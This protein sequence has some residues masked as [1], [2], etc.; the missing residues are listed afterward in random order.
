MWI[1]YQVWTSFAHVQDPLNCPAPES[2]HCDDIRDFSNI[3]PPGWSQT[4]IISVFGGRLDLVSLRTTQSGNQ[5]EHSV[6]FTCWT[7]PI[8]TPMERVPQRDLW[9]RGQ[10]LG[11][12]PGLQTPNTVTCGLMVALQGASMLS[13]VNPWS[14]S[15]PDP[16]ITLVLLLSEIQWEETVRG[17][18]DQRESSSYGSGL[19]W[20]ELAA[21]RLYLLIRKPP[22]VLLEALFHLHHTKFSSTWA[23][24]C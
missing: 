13:R 11:L 9:G 6:G 2:V 3:K 15:S 5:W 18:F 10:Q 16:F 1:T 12:Q 19:D 23:C 22:H 14:F 4:V 20:T 8:S 24:Y 17:Q 21:T 7:P